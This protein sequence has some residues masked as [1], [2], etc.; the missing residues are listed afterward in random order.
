MLSLSKYRQNIALY[1][2]RIHIKRHEITF[3]EA[4]N[5]RQRST[6]YFNA[7]MKHFLFDHTMTLYCN[8]D[9]APAIFTQRNGH[10]SFLGGDLV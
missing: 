4:L 1:G 6:F 7:T 9:Y 3:A 5:L 10:I 2:G 8:N